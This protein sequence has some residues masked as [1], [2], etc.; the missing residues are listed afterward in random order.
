MWPQLQEN[1]KNMVSRME[2]ERIQ[3]SNILVGLVSVR[4]KSASSFVIV[5]ITEFESWMWNQV[6]ID[7]VVIIINV[8]LISNCINIKLIL[9]HQEC[10]Q[11]LLDVGNKDGKMEME[12]LP[13]SIC[14]MGLPSLRMMDHCWLL[15]HGITGS[16]TSNIKVNYP[17]CQF[18]LL[19]SQHFINFSFLVLT[20]FH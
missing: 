15:M 17:P 19:S 16:G 4:N 5:T 13:N 1:M 14:P 10:W 6:S 11:M 8:L 18:N 3:G 12:S 2:T 9:F 20:F 7:D